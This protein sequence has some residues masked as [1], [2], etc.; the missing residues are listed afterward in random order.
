M[1][2]APVRK[3]S[4]VETVAM[5]A[6]ISVARITGLRDSLRGSSLTNES[7]DGS[8]H[9]AGGQRRGSDRGA[10]LL[11]QVV[12]GDVG[13]GVRAPVRGQCCLATASSTMKCSTIGPS[14]WAGK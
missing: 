3:A 1:G 7:L 11:A 13:H 14:A 10:A 8:H 12:H 5:K 4:M 2:W 6:T 9:H